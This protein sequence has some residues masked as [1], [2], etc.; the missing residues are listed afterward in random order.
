MSTC[1]CTY[2]DVPVLPVAYNNPRMAG[3][4]YIREIRRI[5]E[6]TQEDVAEALGLSHAQVQRHESG[7]QTLS[8]DWVMRYA[9][10]F[11]CH[12]IMIID[13]PSATIPATQTE[14]EVLQA[15]RGLSDREQKMFSA[16]LTTFS[17]DMPVL[18]DQAPTQIPNPQSKGAKK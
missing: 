6:M 1:F 8:M 10:V 9:E 7:K 17:S 4:N 15:F 14:K 18:P 3:K 13:G 11:G 12:P 16:M 2:Q 5:K